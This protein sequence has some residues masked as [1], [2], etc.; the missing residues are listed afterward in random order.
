M[1]ADIKQIKNPGS[2]LLAI[3]IYVVDAASDENKLI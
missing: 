3:T 1:I 2:Y